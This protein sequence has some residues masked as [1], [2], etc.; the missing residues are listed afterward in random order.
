MTAGETTI[1]GE[2]RGL[3]GEVGQLSKAVSGCESRMSA[4]EAVMSER[5]KAAN[6]ASQSSNNAATWVASICAVAVF[7]LSALMYF[8][9]RSSSAGASVPT[10][11]KSSKYTGTL[12]VAS[13]AVPTN[14]SALV[15]CPS[16]L[17]G[18]WWH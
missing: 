5:D 11:N 14:E 16:A 13:C 2:I 7:A 8:F 4:I 9:P 1:L 17:D 12:A 6:D 10:A 15:D 3:R 18:E